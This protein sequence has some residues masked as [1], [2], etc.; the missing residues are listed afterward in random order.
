MEFYNL[1]LGLVV[2]ASRLGQVKLMTMSKFL[3]LIQAF[4]VKP[5]LTLIFQLKA[6][7]KYLV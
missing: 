3:I 1:D 4:I 6:K 2:M 5:C 7:E